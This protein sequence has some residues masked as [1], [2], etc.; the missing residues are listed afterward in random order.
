M[1]N[2]VGQTLEKIKLQ[3]QNN[4]IKLREKREC[5]HFFDS[6][7]FAMYLIRYLCA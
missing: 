2:P 3:E 7:N 4:E 5:E 1:D 6:I